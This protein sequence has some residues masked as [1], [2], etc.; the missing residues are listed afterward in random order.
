MKQHLGTA[1]YAASPVPVDPVQQHVYPI[2]P[3]YAASHQLPTEN[4]LPMSEMT[5]AVWLALLHPSH[6][7]AETISTMPS[8]RYITVH[9]QTNIW[10]AEKGIVLMENN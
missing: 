6:Q 1:W 9:V 5:A 7:H 8:E 3:V 2:H 4:L 10:K